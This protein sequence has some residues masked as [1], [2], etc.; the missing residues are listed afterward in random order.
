[1]LLRGS[2]SVGAGDMNMITARFWQDVVLTQCSFY[3]HRVSTHC[4]IAD[5]P[6]RDFFEQME[7][8]NATYVDP[9]M[10][11]WIGKIWQP[12]TIPTYVDE[13]CENAFGA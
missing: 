13:W 2:A 11:E 4:N 9:I 10:P 12:L 5:G 1:M 6:S 3:M 7:Q 8:L